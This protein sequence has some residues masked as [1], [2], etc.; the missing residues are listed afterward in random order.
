[1]GNLLRKDCVK[2]DKL[3]HLRQKLYQKAKQNPRF[4]FYTLYAHIYR[5]DVL[6]EAWRRV[7]RNKGSA[8]VDNVSF[9]DIEDSEKGIKGFLERIRESL[10]NRVYNPSPVRRTYIPKAN[11]SERPLGIPT[12]QDRVIQMATLL[13]LE[14]IFESNFLECS[15]GFRPERNAH[16]AL[17]DIKLNLQ[18]GYCAISVDR[19]VLKKRLQKRRN[20]RK[21][22]KEF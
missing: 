11:G 22:A 15:Y 10:K 9:E 12:I 6:W 20:E 5:E 19:Q 21:L 18:Q 13:I 3:S 14:P 4:K 8:G 16:Q 17:A 2:A 1:M 7:R